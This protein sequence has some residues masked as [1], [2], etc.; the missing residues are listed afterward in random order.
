MPNKLQC[1][2][3][4]SQIR[5]SIDEWGHTPIHLHCYTCDINIGAK[6][7]NKCEELLQKYNKPHTYLEYYFNDIQLLLENHQLLIN[8]EEENN[9]E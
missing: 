8:R 2:I 7:F 5:F 6:S 3:C 9:A 1:P 4:G